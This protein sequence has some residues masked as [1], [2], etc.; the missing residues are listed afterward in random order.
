MSTTRIH[1]TEVGAMC[2]H[3]VEDRPHCGS[4]G[5]GHETLPIQLR[6]A[7]ASP[8]AWRDALVGDVTPDGWVALH[9]LDSDEV[10]PVWHHASVLRSWDA[11]AYHPGSGL[12]ALGDERLSVVIR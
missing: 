11:V 3:A 2:T 9:L 10:V 6:V 1:T 12:V 8:S 5:G 4:T 7:A